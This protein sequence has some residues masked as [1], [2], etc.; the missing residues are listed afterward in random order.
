[1]RKDRKDKNGGVMLMIKSRINLICVEYGNWKVELISAQ[2]RGQKGKS[3]MGVETGGKRTNVQEGIDWKE[4]KKAID[5]LKCSIAAGVDV[6]DMWP[7]MEKEKSTR[8]V[9]KNNYCALA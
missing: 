2:M 9:Q 1:M 4:I 3:S 7:C 6:H 5:K 8:W